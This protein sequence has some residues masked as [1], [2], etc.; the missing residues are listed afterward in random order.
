MLQPVKEKHLKTLLAQDLIY[1]KIRKKNLDIMDPQ[2]KL[3]QSLE[4]GKRE[5]E[6][7]VLENLLRFSQESVLLVGQTNIIVSYRRRLIVVD[8]VMNKLL[9]AKSMLKL[10]SELLAKEDKDLLGK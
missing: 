3:L 8:G 9:Q 6:K 7:V 5:G 10:K 4:Q 2:G 1:E